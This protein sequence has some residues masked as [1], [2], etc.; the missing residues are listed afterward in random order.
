VKHKVDHTH[1]QGDM[2]VCFLTHG[3]FA[4]DVNK[5]VAHHPSDFSDIKSVKIPS[6]LW[7]WSTIALTKLVLARALLHVQTVVVCV[8]MHHHSVCYEIQFDMR[9]S[10]FLVKSYD[11][12]T[13]INFSA[14]TFKLHLV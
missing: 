8:T 1:Q 14:A 5:L 4:P 7:G 9:V 2:F 10:S 11:N 6:P 13:H 12:N 3:L